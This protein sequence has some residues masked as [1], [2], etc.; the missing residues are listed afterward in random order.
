MTFNIDFCTNKSTQATTNPPYKPQKSTYSTPI[1]SKP[2][3]VLLKNQ[4]RWAARTK[5]GTAMNRAI[6]Q[7]GVYEVTPNDS[8]SIR[9]YKNGQRNTEPWCGHFVSWVY[10]DNPDLWGHEKYTPNIK[11]KAVE[12][13]MYVNKNKIGSGKNGTYMPKRGDLLMWINPS[14]IGGHVGIIEK[15]YYKNGELVIQTIEGNNTSDPNGIAETA[16]TKGTGKGPEGVVRR[17]Y[18]LTEIMKNKRMNGVVRVEDWL[19]K[20][21]ERK[22]SKKA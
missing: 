19:A 21:E 4:A 2:N 14:G 12:N 5:V 22:L 11:K 3:P 15:C 10:G 20:A 13:G 6:S 16:T 8:I 7:I 1:W 18:T 9:M 17:T